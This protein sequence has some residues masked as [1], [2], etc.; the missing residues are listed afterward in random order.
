MFTATCR[1][2]AIDV[3]FGVQSSG[4]VGL[5][6]FRRGTALEFLKNFRT[7]FSNFGAAIGRHG[8]TIL[9]QPIREELRSGGKSICDLFILVCFEGV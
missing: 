3:V 1:A 4:D 9:F 6:A 8:V 7:L 2:S 5:L